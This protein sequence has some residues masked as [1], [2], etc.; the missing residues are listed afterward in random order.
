MTSLPVLNKILIAPDKFKGSLTASEFCRIAED[1]FHAAFPHVETVSVPLADGG[2][3]SLDCYVQATGAKTVEDAFTG[4]DGQRV[5]ARF[6]L[7]GDTAFI[8]MSA[9]AGLGLTRLRNPLYTT[10]Y[11]VGEQI[12]RACREGA[13]R[14][15]LSVGGSAT[16]DAGCGMAAALGWRFLDGEGN[17]FI[18][19]GGTLERIRAIVPP[20]PSEVR[21]VTLCDVT[22]PLFG[23]NGA[24]YVYAPQK[25]ASPEDVEVLDRNLRH[26]GNI[27]SAYGKNLTSVPGAGAAGGLGAGSIFFLNAKLQKGAET[28][29]ELT[30]LR[31]KIAEADLVVTGEGK[32]DF[33]TLQGKTV[34]A[35]Y[36]AAQGKRFVAFCGCAEGNLPFECIEIN[37]ASLSLAE[38][39]SLSPE[40][41]R[42]A[43]SEFSS[44][45]N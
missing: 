22:N 44:T 11:G 1:V 21:F 35:L 17:D 25:G 15:F 34:G 38:N 19:V 24:A 4:P 41:L 39:V 9:T 37:D 45:W 32:I 33:Q 31:E 18:P 36:S 3:G 30:R 20:R 7:D 29:F 40:H 16:N 12:A 5:R 2:E 42:D 26:F 14:I 6:A 27:C 23:S 43:L 13:K 8:E 10:T 28:F